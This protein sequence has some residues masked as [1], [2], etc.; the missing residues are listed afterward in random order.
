MFVALPVLA[1]STA[2]STRLYRRQQLVH[3]LI[4]SGV[5]VEFHPR[6]G[7]LGIL[8][9]AAAPYCLRQVSGLEG[10][11]L[12]SPVIRW[13]PRVESV[14]LESATDAEIDDLKNCAGL[15]SLMIGDATEI[16]PRA[17]AN[18][19]AYVSL[20]HLELY[21]GAHLTTAVAQHN[22]LTE[23]ILPDALGSDVG[24]LGKLKQ[25]RWL[26]LSHMQLLKDDDLTALGRLH[27]LRSLSLESTNLAGHNL[28]FL[29]DLKRLKSLDLSN[30]ANLSDSVMQS[31]SPLRL[32]FLHM[33]YYE[34]GQNDVTDSGL[35]GLAN[36]FASLE[37]LDIFATHVSRES[38]SHLKQMTALK[39]LTVGDDV[40]SR[41]ELRSV[42]PS[43]QLRL[44]RAWYRGGI[45]PRGGDE[46]VSVDGAEKVSGTDMVD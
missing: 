4:E 25:L 8:P 11:L 26:N 15:K 39:M 16:S 35:G 18:L 36:S 6:T 44:V 22:E 5:Q 13:F 7:M 28:S 3:R 17:L 46:T 37:Q 10:E 38:A 19:A 23:L 33:G 24:S 12:P 40:F 43:T 21:E 14:D 31:M 29:H 9:D 20:N 1:V 42:L 27:Q 41:D 2:L 45:Q 32:R 30:C 34:G